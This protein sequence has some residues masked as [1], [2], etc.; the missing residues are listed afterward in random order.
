MRILLAL[1][2]ASLAWSQT[3]PNLN[4][5]WKANNDK[6]KFARPLGDAE[7]TVRIEQNGPVV[8]QEFITMG[9]HVDHRMTSMYNTSEPESTNT[10]R[11]NKVVSK[12]AWSDGSLV[13][14]TGNAQEKWTLSPDNN[15]LTV[16]RTG[17]RDAEN[18]VLERQPESAAEIFTRTPRTAKEVY[19]NVQELN[20]PAYQLGDTMEFYTKALGVHCAYCHVQGKFDSDD[21]PKKA[22]ARKMIHMAQAINRDNFR[23]HNVVT[24]YT[25]HRGKQEPERMGQ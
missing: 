1:F 11:G 23:D 13:I 7:Y 5:I 24:C 2:V 17:G 22:V 25:C 18:I 9:P 8:K 19:K 6:S 15:T 12:A 21:V 10:V 20:I 4:G 16:A 3:S 14:T